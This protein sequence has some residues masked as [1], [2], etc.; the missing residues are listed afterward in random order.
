[1]AKRSSGVGVAGCSYVANAMV[2]KG[3]AQMT[4][5]LASDWFALRANQDAGASRR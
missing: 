4:K 3:G 5:T 2:R 1:V